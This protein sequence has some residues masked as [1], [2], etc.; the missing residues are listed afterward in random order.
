VARQAGLL[1][2]TFVA[3]LALLAGITFV[4]RAPT[5]GG[6]QSAAPASNGSVS[7]SEPGT[8]SQ[9]ASPASSADPSFGASSS[10]AAS[11]GAVGDP[12]LIGAGDIASCGS[13][14]DEATADLIGRLPRAA[15]IF[16]AGDNA[17]E[18]GTASQFADC[19]DPSWG[20]F[21]DRTR[22]ALGNHDWET[23]D[24]TGYFDYFG[25]VAGTPPN[26]WYSYDLGAWHVIVLN[27]N[28]PGRNGCAADSPQ[29]T[30]L[31]RDLAADRARCTLAIW[32]HPRFSSGEHGNDTTYG[33]FWNLLYAAGA[34]VVVNGHDHDYERFLPQSPSAEKDERRGMVEFVVGTG[35]GGELRD[36]TRTIVAN[37]LVRASRIA[38]VLELTLHATTYDFQFV[39]VDGSFSDRGTT[40]CH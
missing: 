3:V 37:S 18:S 28:C 2:V 27:S 35:G 16:T 39:S 40:S 20:R 29:G 22:P 34:D 19:Y 14:G 13:Q 15:A 17:Y 38:G 7:P 25:A 21:K 30:W 32:H 23:R 9:S 12:I 31:Q 10:P 36:F 1:A 5:T 11:G 33:P 6:E 24:A 8:P 26:G 4:V